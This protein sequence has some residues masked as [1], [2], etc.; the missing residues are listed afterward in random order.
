MHIKSCW[1]FGVLIPWQFHMYIV[2]VQ[3]FVSCGVSS[4]NNITTRRIASSS[5]AVTQLTKQDTNNCT[6][7]CL[8]DKTNCNT[9]RFHQYVVSVCLFD[10]LFVGLFVFV[11]VFV[12]VWIFGLKLNICCFIVPCNMKRLYKRLLWTITPNDI[13]HLLTKTSWGTFDITKVDPTKVHFV[14]HTWFC[15]GWVVSNC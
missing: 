9:V 15:I 8:W 3:L 6:H 4:V 14:S 7:L 11:F 2:L 12:C 10:W 13:L 1:H 5:N